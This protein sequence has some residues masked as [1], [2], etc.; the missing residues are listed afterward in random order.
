MSNIR[1]KPE[2]NKAGPNL[3]PLDTMPIFGVFFSIGLNYFW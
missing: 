1:E 3:A 2:I